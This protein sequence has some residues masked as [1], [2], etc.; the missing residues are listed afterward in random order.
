VIN[1]NEL[2][3]RK[4]R[5]APFWLMTILMMVIFVIAI[6][7]HARVLCGDRNKMISSLESNYQESRAGLGIVADGSIV[8][9]FTAKSGTW[10]VLITRPG[11]P[12]C[13]IGTGN[14]WEMQ[15]NPLKPKGSRT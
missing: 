9:L 5:Y 10:T 13:V 14:D 1:M 2:Y 11:G 8:E 15:H 12:T 4:H 7:A 3:K 6:S